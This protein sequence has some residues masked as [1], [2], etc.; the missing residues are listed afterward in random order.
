[1]SQGAFQKPTHATGPAAREAAR[2]AP[3]S[4]PSPPVGV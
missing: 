2:A 3:A 1:M 4:W